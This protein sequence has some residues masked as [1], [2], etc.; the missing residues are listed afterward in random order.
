M[1]PSESPSKLVE[2]LDWR[3]SAR[4]PRP[5]PTK[6]SAPPTEVVRA[7][8]GK[9]VAQMRRQ[10]PLVRADAPDA[11]FD[12]FHEIRRLLSRVLAP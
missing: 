11:V 8:L 7:W 10:D 3:T 5:L 12:N 1:A 2:A 6:K 4:L 9:Q